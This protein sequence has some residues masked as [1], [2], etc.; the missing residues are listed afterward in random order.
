MARLLFEAQR[1]SWASAPG[2]RR[3]RS[4]PT[5]ARR[6]QNPALAGSLYA[7]P[8]PLA[9]IV[10]LISASI[11]PLV[12][13]CATAPPSPRGP[14]PGSSWC[15]LVVPREMPVSQR[16]RRIGR[17]SC[18]ILRHCATA[19]PFGTEPGASSISRWNCGSRCRAADPSP[20]G[21]GK[22]WNYTPRSITSVQ[23]RQSES[24]NPATA[25]PRRPALVMMLGASC[26]CTSGANRA[27]INPAA[28]AFSPYGAMNSCRA[29]RS[30]RESI[31]GTRCRC[32]PSARY[33]GAT[34]G[35]PTGN[36]WK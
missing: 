18:A 29:S 1:P 24:R 30:R 19:P 35:N 10:Y 11:R 6:S 22:Q 3:G 14:R 25:I 13:S 31:S 17:P 5:V 36:T 32:L 16:L 20:R 23:G 2:M 26:R 27:A 4:A 28:V 8:Q 33:F 7:P 21:A 15:S 9:S 34:S 12:P